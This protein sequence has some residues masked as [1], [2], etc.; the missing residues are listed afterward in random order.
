MTR[1]GSYSA[2]I[3][4]GPARAKSDLE[5][6]HAS[7]SSPESTRTRAA[8][9]VRELQRLLGKKTMENEILREAVEVMKSR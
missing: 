8:K 1:N 3:R 9:Q 5:A 4:P 6:D 2:S 7:T